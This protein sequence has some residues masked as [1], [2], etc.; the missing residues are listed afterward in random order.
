VRPSSKFSKTAATGIRVPRNTH[1][2][3]TFP[4]TLSTAGHFDQSS[5]IATLS[6]VNSSRG[7]QLGAQSRLYW[8][9]MTRHTL[10]LAVRHLHP[11]ICP[12][13]IN[14][15]GLPRCIGSLTFESSCSYSRTSEYSHFHIVVFSALELHS[16]YQCQRLGF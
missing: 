14:I 12:A 15:Q 3:L 11:C 9:R 2:P 4:G 6:L 1:A 16:F 7:P 8:R 5:N 13:L 10:P